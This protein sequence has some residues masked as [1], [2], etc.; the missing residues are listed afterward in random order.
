MLNFYEKY[1]VE[2]QDYNEKECTKLK[3]IHVC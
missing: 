1:D 3:K 2:E